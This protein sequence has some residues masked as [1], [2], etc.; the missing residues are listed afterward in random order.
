[1]E[2]AKD[3]SAESYT[4]YL[5]RL[6]KGDEEGCLHIARQTAIDLAGLHSLYIGLIQSSQYRVGELWEAGSISVATEHMATATNTFVA[7]SCYAP[8]ARRAAGG[9][10][11]TVACTL[12]EF[13]ELGARLT[14]D[15]LECDGWDVD[16]YGASL[17]VRDLIGAVR[18]RRP[19][20]L[21]LSAALTQHLGGLR[22]VVDAV[23][24]AL[25]G[26]SPPIVVGGNA[27]RPAPDLWKLVGAD[28]YA[29]D[30]SAAVEVL[31][32]FRD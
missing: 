29:P 19:R 21:G 18:D 26:D 3:L 30:A 12:D 11:A 7:L 17:P 23:R 15:L 9:P 4:D 6:L 32:E 20:V 10:K 22:E 2:I 28:R 5:E 14:A 25:G 1:M 24:E 31:R 8:I 16:Y 13:H 27:F